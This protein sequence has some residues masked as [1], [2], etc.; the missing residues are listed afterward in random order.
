[1]KMAEQTKGTTNQG[2]RIQFNM[3]YC[4]EIT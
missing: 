1:M 2:F 3:K 4:T